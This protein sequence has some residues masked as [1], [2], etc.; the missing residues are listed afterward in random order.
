MDGNRRWAKK[1]ELNQIEGHR[2]GI[3][4]AKF[5]AKYCGN[6]NIKELTLYA[7]SMQNWKRSKVEI[8]SLLKLFST[9]WLSLIVTI[10]LPGRVW[11]FCS[12]F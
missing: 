1:N 2:K 7:F 5:I 12:I 6:Q 4:T 10:F 9:F 8:K 11:P 3:E